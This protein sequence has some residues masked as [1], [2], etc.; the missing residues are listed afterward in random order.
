MIQFRPPMFSSLALG[1]LAGFV[2]IVPASMAQIRMVELPPSTPERPPSLEP[3]PADPPQAR[4]LQLDLPS[5]EEAREADAGTRP[6][7]RSLDPKAEAAAAEARALAEAEA[8]QL[9]DANA[10]QLAA[11]EAE[12]RQIAA[13]R[14]AQE[15]RVAQYRVQQQAHDAALTAYEVEL[16]ASEQARRRWEADVA[17]CRA[18]DRSRCSAPLPSR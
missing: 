18:G 10:R 4:G 14:Q 7:V 11:A 15:E 13:D 12:T 8:A 9:R 5:P 17:A 1:L 16:K 3:L 2:A 6:P